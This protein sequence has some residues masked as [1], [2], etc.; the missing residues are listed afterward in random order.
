MFNHNTAIYIQEKKTNYNIYGL[1][2]R[3]ILEVFFNIDDYEKKPVLLL[4]LKLSSLLE[5]ISSVLLNLY[6]SLKEGLISN[7]MEDSWVSLILLKELLKKYYSFYILFQI[8]IYKKKH[9]YNFL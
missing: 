4:L 3:N 6:L 5:V 1:I 9:I 7:F 8:F 2:D